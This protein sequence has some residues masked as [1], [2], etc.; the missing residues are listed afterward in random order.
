MKRDEHEEIQRLLDGSMSP[1]EFVDFQQ[2]LRESPD[3]L[4]LYSGYALLHH[5]LSEEY[6]QRKVPAIAH[7]ASASRRGVAL[8]WAAIIVLLLGAG[9]FFAK[10]KPS[11]A[12][13]LQLPLASLVFSED[14]GWELDRGLRPVE[15]S[16]AVFTG[17]TLILSQGQATLKEPDGTTILLDGP[18]KL[19]IG[20]AKELRIDEGHVLCRVEKSNT[21]L[22][23][24]TPGLI[25]SDLGGSQLGIDLRHDLPAELHVIAGEARLRL[26]PDQTGE[27]LSPGDKTGQVLSPGDAARIGGPSGIERFPADPS[28]FK[29]SSLKFSDALTD[30]FVKSDWRL[31]FG[32]PSIS[33][34]GIEG[35]NYTAFH[36]LPESCA[37][38]AVI[39]VTVR[40]ANPPTGKFHTD[41]WAGI[42]FFSKGTEQ[43]FFGDCFGA[44]PTWGLDIKQGIPI[45]NPPKAVA[46]AR[47]VTLRYDRRTGDVSLHDGAVPLGLAF[48]SG[49]V[50][51]GL[52]FDELRVGASSG[53]A[54]ALRSLSIR[55]GNEP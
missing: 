36:P 26:I 19:E 1:A 14:A 44:E 11:P 25:A 47:T 50:P 48:C 52:E 17:T 5:S 35:E 12:A 15:G 53:A 46:G 49:K 24:I 39:L 8:A 31:D 3:L 29:A 34:N 45:V 42:S 23:I 20:S 28:R 51:A 41:G 55:V 21:S 22:R 37:K 27:V 16:V 54:L 7:A 4:Q 38:A 43:L 9:V 33:A 2:R 40:T 10:N 13:A 30:A 6:E 18:A 32:T